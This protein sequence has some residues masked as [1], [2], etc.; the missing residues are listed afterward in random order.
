MR[1][2]DEKQLD[3]LKQGVDVWNK[4]REDNLEVMI[5]LSNQDLSGAALS[6]ADLTGA[7]L[8]NADLSNANFSNADLSNADLS[9]AK[10]N[11]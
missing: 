3:I 4:W 8:R 1:V 10:H 6:G 7:D 2:A 9:G 11:P 5:D